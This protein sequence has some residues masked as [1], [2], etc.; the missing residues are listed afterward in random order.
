MRPQWAKRDLEKIK[1]VTISPEFKTSLENMPKPKFSKEQ[2][3]VAKAHS[4]LG[5]ID[6]TRLNTDAKIKLSY[7]C[8]LLESLLFMDDKE[9]DN[10][11]KS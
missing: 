4:M 10:Y 3:V 2:K 7:A 11:A 9:E 8:G 1:E 5:S 6:R